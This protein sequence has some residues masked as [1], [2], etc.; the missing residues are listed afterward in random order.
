MH[1]RARSPLE[2]KEESRYD[3]DKPGLS[4]RTDNFTNMVWKLTTHVGFGVSGAEYKGKF[5]FFTAAFFFPKGNQRGD[6]RRNVLAMGSVRHHCLT[7]GQVGDPVT[8]LSL[9]VCDLMAPP[10]NTFWLEPFLF[11]VSPRR[12]VVFVGYCPLGFLGVTVRSLSRDKNMH[13][14][15]C[16]KSNLTRVSPSETSVSSTRA[17]RAHRVSLQQHRLH[18]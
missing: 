13:Q 17:W 1:P 12:R 8:S 15:Y 4:T 10:I 16:R 14:N 2:Q 11:F 3:Y 5:T 18:F 9:A 6:F 7:C